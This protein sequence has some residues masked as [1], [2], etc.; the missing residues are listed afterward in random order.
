MAE[1]APIS[2]QLQQIPIGKA[3]FVK[4]PGYKTIYANQFQIGMTPFDVQLVL[5]QASMAGG[6]G[7]NEIQATLF[8]SPQEAKTVASLMTKVV[9]DYERQFG[10]IGVSSQFLLPAQGPPPAAT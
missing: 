4:A 8:L 10:P 7:V 1:E 3:E 2:L 9:A 6:V 5:A